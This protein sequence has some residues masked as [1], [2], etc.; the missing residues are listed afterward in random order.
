MDVPSFDLERGL[1]NGGH[2]LV[3]GVDEAGRGA[4]AGPLAIGLVI[5]KRETI[6]RNEDLLRG[7]RDSKQ[8]TPSRRRELSGLVGRVALVARVELVSHRRI[9]ASNVN[10]ATAAGLRSLLCRISPAPS[11][12]MMDGS[13]KFDVGV[14]FVPVIRGDRLSLTIAAASIIAKVRRDSIMEKIDSLYPGYGLAR[15]K[16]YGTALHIRAI[17]ENGYTPV[18]R[19]SYEPVRSRFFPDIP[20]EPGL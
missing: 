19:I 5:F 3:A 15:H 11:V 9:D 20:T 18:H 1:I 16:G 12:V 8:L 14:P 7:V 10:A 2:D 17:M 13:F 6:E 4:L